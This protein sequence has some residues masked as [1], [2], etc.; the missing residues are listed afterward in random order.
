MQQNLSSIQLKQ[1]HH[2]I[3]KSIVTIDWVS[4]KVLLDDHK[5]PSHTGAQEK[6][7]LNK[8]EMSSFQLILQPVHIL[9]SFN[10]NCKNPS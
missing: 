3:S 5:T 8:V 4:I 6:W 10:T 2:R 9:N 1:Y 7:K